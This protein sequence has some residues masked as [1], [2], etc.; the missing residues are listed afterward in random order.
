MLTKYSIPFY[1][2]MCY[3]L[4]LY[5]LNLLIITC[6][7]LYFLFYIMSFLKGQHRPFKYINMSYSCIDYNIR[8][9]CDYN[10]NTK[11]KE[12]QHKKLAK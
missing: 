6:F 2:R 5:S 12:Q 8:S 9:L 7:I 11:N 3:T 10:Y 4:L 1:Y